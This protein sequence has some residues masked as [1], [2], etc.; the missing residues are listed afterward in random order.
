M[1]S[2]DLHLLCCVSC[3]VGTIIKVA[4]TVIWKLA[5]LLVWTFPRA[6]YKC[7][8]NKKHSVD[9]SSVDG[10]ESRRD[11][12]SE[13]ENGT[14]LNRRLSVASLKEMA[15]ESTKSLSKVPEVHTQPRVSG[16]Q[17]SL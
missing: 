8:K 10:Q 7:C 5:K 9:N 16:Q 2:K 14:N 15:T 3:I 13:K 11:T 6:I 4:V 12:K 1:E 17:A